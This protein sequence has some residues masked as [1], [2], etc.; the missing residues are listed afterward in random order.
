MWK[1]K[2]QLLLARKR[3]KSKK[4]DRKLNCVS[5]YLSDYSYLHQCD[6]EK[7]QRQRIHSTRQ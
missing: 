5:C 4:K 2:V 7:G 3:R 1:E 6:L